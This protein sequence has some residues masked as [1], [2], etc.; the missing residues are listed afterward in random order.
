MHVVQP[1]NIHHIQQQ[2]QRS[3]VKTKRLAM[4]DKTRTDLV[5]H[6]G[7]GLVHPYGHAGLPQLLNITPLLSRLIVICNDSDLRHVLGS[8][9]TRGMGVVH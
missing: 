5:V 4:V 6:M 1:K 2:M 9:Y 3:H 8:R 7:R